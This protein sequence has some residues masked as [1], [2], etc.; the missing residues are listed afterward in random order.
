MRSLLSVEIAAR[1]LISN[2]LTHMWMTSFVSV[3]PSWEGPCEGKYNIQNSL[4]SIF[5]G[6]DSPECSSYDVEIH[7]SRLPSD[8]RQ[9]SM[10]AIGAME[11]ESI[12]PAMVSSSSVVQEDDS[13]IS[14]TS[15][16]VLS[17]SK[18]QENNSFNGVSNS[19]STATS[20]SPT[21]REQENLD[22]N[23]SSPADDSLSSN[24]LH[25][26]NYDSLES[27][28][29]TTLPTESVSSSLVQSDSLPLDQACKASP[30]TTESL[31]SA[32][33]VLAKPPPDVDSH[34][35]LLANSVSSSPVMQENTSSSQ[36]AANT[37]Q[38]VTS[39]S[40]PLEQDYHH[41]DQPGSTNL[42]ASQ[43]RLSA[44]SNSSEQDECNINSAGNAS[45]ELLASSYSMD[46]VDHPINS[47][48]NTTVP[49][50]HSEDSTTATKQT[51]KKRRLVSRLRNV[52]HQR[53][54]K[55]LRRR[56]QWAIDTCL[57]INLNSIVFQ[58]GQKYENEYI[59]A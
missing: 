40:P 5:H 56:V 35:L 42:P 15:P 21:E 22:S 24:S 33:M 28:S 19:T 25:Q 48:S 10:N 46:H 14:A 11:T 50:I 23:N 27:V 45:L 36:S 31:S 16:A 41:P 30:L 57:E 59:N 26:D 9:D 13:S 47:A 37:A 20:L 18:L 43:S 3:R 1:P 49:A 55:R 34:G 29:H 2:V 17:C 53:L 8:D 54:F 39:V 7:C 58:L 32:S 4:P 12:V 52:V 38:Q 44:A 51:Q 6:I